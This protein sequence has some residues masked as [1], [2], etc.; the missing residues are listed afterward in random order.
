[1]LALQLRR[2]HSHSSWLR[3]SWQDA[4]VLCRGC[5]VYYFIKPVIRFCRRRGSF[6]FIEEAAEA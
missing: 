6:H 3:G 5:K 2:G 1:M 4:S